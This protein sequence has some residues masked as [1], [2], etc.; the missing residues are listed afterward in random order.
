MTGTPFHAS[1]AIRHATAMIQS[2]VTVQMIA[3][4]L[5][6]AQQQHGVESVCH[7]LCWKQV[8]TCKKSNVPFQE[9]TLISLS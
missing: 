4:I 9:V 5:K 3:R 7:E 1:L 8:N 2:H 6:Y